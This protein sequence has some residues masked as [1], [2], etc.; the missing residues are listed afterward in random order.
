MDVVAK[1][2]ENDDFK[3]LVLAGGNDDITSLNIKDNLDLT[4]LRENAI[5]SAKNMF[6][7]AEAALREYPTLIK[8]II[9]RTTPRFDPISVDPSRLK[10]QLAH[11]V[12]TV[13]F[14]LWCDSKFKEKI[15]LGN[16]DLS[17]WS[18]L[19]HEKVFGSSDLNNYDGIQMLGTAGSQVPVCFFDSPASSAKDE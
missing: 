13:Y 3:T 7:I 14:D 1:E 18:Y 11:L 15:D 4:T 9:V 2:L 16:H 10:P 17:E 19:P 6:N 12:D 8:V 5:Q